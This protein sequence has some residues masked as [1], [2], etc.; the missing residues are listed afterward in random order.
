MRD[1]RGIL[2]TYENIS[3]PAERQRSDPKNGSISVSQG[4]T[5]DKGS[6]PAPAYWMRDRRWRRCI[7]WHNGHI[8]ATASV[9]CLVKRGE[10]GSRRK[11]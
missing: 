3:P 9:F 2:E 11:L 6:S 10:K 5:A 8:T 1:R 7:T 4:G